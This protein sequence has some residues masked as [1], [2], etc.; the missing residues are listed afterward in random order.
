MNMIRNLTNIVES[1][2]MTFDELFD[3]LADERRRIALYCLD[4]RG[5]ELGLDELADAV[6][7]LERGI[8]DGES[9]HLSDEDV[10]SV[11]IDLYHTHVPKMEDCGIV[12][13]D[14]ASG[15]VRLRSVLTGFDFEAVLSNVRG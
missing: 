15:I 7:R 13:H 1:G 14:P 10:Q 6:A 3:V 11:Y 4:T 9:A 8:D 2:S 5:R 12:E